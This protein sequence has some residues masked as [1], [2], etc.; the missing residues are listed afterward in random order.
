M[1]QQRAVFI[2]V[3]LIYFSIADAT[4]SQQHSNIFA[5][6]LFKTLLSKKKM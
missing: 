3:D 4:G 1:F 2:H 5:K 6:P